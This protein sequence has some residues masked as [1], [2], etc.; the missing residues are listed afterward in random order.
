MTIAS[1]SMLRRGLMLYVGF[2]IFLILVAAWQGPTNVTL[3]MSQALAYS[4]IAL[5][6]NIQF[7][8]GGL[9]NFGIMGFVMLGGFG[10]VFVSADHNPA[11]W[12]S[13]GPMLLGRAVL[14]FL[15]G[16]L[17]VWGAHKS[18]R[19]G[20]RGRLR[21]L[22]IVVAW[23][24]AYVVYRGQIDPAAA[25]IESTS[26]WIGGL[27]LHPVLGW[28]FGGVLA[29][30]IAYVVG[31]IA[32]GLRT[33]YLAIATIGIAEIIRAF[34]KNMDWLTRG[35][36][37]V[38]P[39]PWPTPLPQQLQADGVSIN[40]SFLFARLGF[41]AVM[42]LLLVV[43]FYL[44]AR[45]YGGPWGRMM[46]S[47]RDNYVA[48]ASMGK[49]ITGRQ[50][51]IFI[52]GSVLMGMGGA[53]LASFNQIFDPNGYQPIHHN[54][55]I[56]VMVIVGGAGNN[57][58]TLLGALLIYTV[59]IISDPASQFVLNNLSAWSDSI[60]WGAIPEITSRSVQM[61]VFVLGI[62]IWLALRYAPR[63][64]LPEVIRRER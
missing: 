7:G 27:A 39:L 2:A 37:T 16:G 32:L 12:S 8:Y 18:E 23:A 59:W 40:N 52:M 25:Y 1:G 14:A 62:V 64:L 15:A 30:L 20:V 36:L 33:D 53:M 21:G 24:A 60:G 38:T 49:N 63:G 48:A 34:I 10:T 46:R 26:G 45:A 56:W 9:F 50:L 51:E 19:I 41:I 4:L 11:F 5:G 17:L 54:F 31:K 58:G 55:M 47:I 43:A 57:W 22:L 28:L 35:T 42:L 3:I 44:V 6:L 13:D 61:R 29:G